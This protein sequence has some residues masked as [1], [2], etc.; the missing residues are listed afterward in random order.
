MT[1]TIRALTQANAAR[2]RQRVTEVRC[3]S[4]SFPVELDHRVNQHPDLVYMF[5]RFPLG[6]IWHGS[7]VSIRCHD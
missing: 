2:L 5:Q 3:V 4:L 7:N 6:N 1:G